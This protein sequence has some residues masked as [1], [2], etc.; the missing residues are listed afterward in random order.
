[1]TKEASKQYYQL[2]KEKIKKRVADYYKNNQDKIVEKNKSYYERNHQRI[3]D[4]QTIKRYILNMN[5]ARK[6]E[7]HNY[8]QEHRQEILDRL[9]VQ[10]KERNEIIVKQ[11]TKPSDKPDDWYDLIRYNIRH[12]IGTN[13]LPLEEKERFYEELNKR[14]RAVYDFPHPTPGK[15]TTAFQY[16]DNKNNSKNL[17][18]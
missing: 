15:Y 8:Y 16:L 11:E 5:L 12:G 10:N 13:T 18:V 1:M 4:T 6:E 7:L 9:K 17:S 3:R 2:H 14:V